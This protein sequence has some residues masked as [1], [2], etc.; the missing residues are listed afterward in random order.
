MVV[1]T[2]SLLIGVIAIVI[3]LALVG[4]FK[5]SKYDMREQEPNGE[6]EQEDHCQ[7]RDRHGNKR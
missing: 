1:M 6:G 2:A 4:R 3:I 7:E 5:E